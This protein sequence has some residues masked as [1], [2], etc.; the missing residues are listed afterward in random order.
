MTSLLRD[1]RE[2]DG[3]KYKVYEVQ[4]SSAQL[5]DIQNKFTLACSEN[6]KLGRELESLRLKVR[7]DKTAE[8]QQ[9]VSFLLSEKYQLEALLKEKERDQENLRNSHVRSFEINLN[10][11]KGQ[12][13]QLKNAGVD[14]KRKIGDLEGRIAQLLTLESRVSIL[15]VETDKLQRSINDKEGQIQVLSQ[16]LTEKERE[17]ED[18][19]KRLASADSMRIYEIEEIRN[20][21]Q[22][23]QVNHKLTFKVLMYL[24]RRERL[25]L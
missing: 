19:R 23:E 5:T 13:E 9:Q 7:D 16:R 15:N 4:N 2:V 24:Y 20:K 1:Q 10:E 17:V 3:L 25:P 11:L 6:E 14:Q 21:S 12:N 18:L 22:A 8:L